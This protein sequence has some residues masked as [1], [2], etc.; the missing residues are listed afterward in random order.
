M[1]EECRMAKC[2]RCGKAMGSAQVCPYCGYGP[3]KSV[4]SRTVGKAAKLTGR[5]LETSVAVTET[6]VKEVTPAVKKVARVGRRGVS[7]AKAET[8][9]VARSL[10]EEDS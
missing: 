10:K 5:A 3:S 4:M 9:K 2:S 8:L 1:L 7:K 6:V